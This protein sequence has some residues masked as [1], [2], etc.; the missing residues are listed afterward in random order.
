M[1]DDLKPPRPETLAGA[2][3]SRVA[4]L[5]HPVHPMLVV[6]PVALLTLVPFTDA[7]HLV[8]G[9]AFF[10]HASFWMTLVALATGCLAAI[11]GLLDMFLIRFVRRHVAA[12]SHMLAAITALAMAA[13]SLA[14]RWPDPVAAVW[15]WGVVIGLTNAAMVTVAGWQGGTLTFRHGIG[16]YGD[17]TGHDE[18]GSDR[19]PPAA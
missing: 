8:L 19:D 3:A 16:V 5:N 17:R 6:Y 7:A 1:R 12:W 10:A 11:A 15:P 2:H 18:S 9:D 4:I 14:L 13:V